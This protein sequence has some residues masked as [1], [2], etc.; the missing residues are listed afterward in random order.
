MI[1]EL[2]SPPPAAAKGEARFA[3]A[4]GWARVIH[5]AAWA[6]IVLIAGQWLATN[7]SKLSH[8]LNLAQIT[9]FDSISDRLAG[10]A[11]AAPAAPAISP[12]EATILDA[13]AVKAGKGKLSAEESAMLSAAL[14]KAQTPVT[15]PPQATDDAGD[16]ANK[17]S[18]VGRHTL[19]YDHVARYALIFSNID[20]MFGALPVAALF[21]AIWRLRQATLTGS[22][23]G[24]GS[25][26]AYRRYGQILYALAAAAGLQQLIDLSMDL[27]H[28][29][30]LGWPHSN[31]TGEL[32]VLPALALF[33]WLVA[34]RLIRWRPK[35]SPR[36]RE[37]EAELAAVRAQADA[38]AQEN[39]QFV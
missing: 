10:P 23:W 38:L 35:R 34:P 20:L 5:I 9:A 13:L 37:L 29:Y 1:D 8:A 15:S 22:R 21:L 3:T 7:N 28:V 17:T 14:L 32:V 12:Q 2:P 36:R 30:P 31:G 26:R 33:L 39:S 24:F 6:S 27:L 18:L 25:D 19:A 11:V 16:H 4:T